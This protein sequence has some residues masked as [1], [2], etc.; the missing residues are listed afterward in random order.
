MVTTALTAAVTSVAT[1]VATAVATPFSNRLQSLIEQAPVTPLITVPA[2]VGALVS[3]CCY[4]LW[5]GKVRT[6]G[7]WAAAVAG[8]VLWPFRRI[9]WPQGLRSW[10]GRMLV[11]LAVGYI[12]ACLGAFTGLVGLVVVRVVAPSGACEPPRELRVITALENVTAL[13]ERAEAYTKE[14]RTDGCAPVRIAV[15][16]APTIEE[17]RYG[18]RNEWLRDDALQNDEPYRRMLGLTPDAWIPTGSAEF[19]LVVQDV[20]EKSGEKTK[21]G[22]VPEKT[23][24]LH[25]LLRKRNEQVGTDRMS[26]AV[27][28]AAKNDLLTSELES[29]GYPLAEIVRRA[30]SKDM[31]LVYPQPAFSTSGA[32]VATT[33]SRAGPQSGDTALHATFD[34]SAN[35]LLCHLRGADQKRTGEDWA[36]LVA[37]VPSHSADEYNRGSDMGIEACAHN[38]LAGRAALTAVSSVDLPTLDY[39]FV[40]INWSE[41]PARREALDA[42]ATWLAHNK[43]FEPAGEGPQPSSPARISA[44]AARP[45]HRVDLQMMIDGSGS[46][47]RSPTASASD[48]H[49]ALA[50]VRQILTDT[51]QVSAGKFF[52]DDSGTAKA[53]MAREGDAGGGE[54]PRGY[55]EILQWI[56]ADKQSGFDEPISTVIS[57]LRSPANSLAVITDGGPFNDEPDPGNA[58]RSIR[59]ALER[60]ADV[61]NLY[62]LTFGGKCPDGLEAPRAVRPSA[63]ASPSDG[64][65]GSLEP[66]AKHVVCDDTAGTDVAGALGR[67]IFQFRVWS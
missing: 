67:M 59:R 7:R 6:S 61:S 19:D 62:I 65:P 50:E 45:G 48:L 4:P 10:A 1:L 29:A 35:A 18:F 20:S 36:K 58:G 12:A 43:L 16:V 66:A 51:D 63:S 28:G 57:G 54:G 37:L 30:R 17:M 15:G 64:P 41:D 23:G 3:I 11:P 44:D 26:I 22:A 31:S 40:E 49:D 56:A 24:S 60:A 34:N 13:R 32:I 46:M 5:R 39:P 27:F 2:S 25:S 42:F 53:P 33:L 55:G 38:P 9:Q 14:Q 21:N 52:A 8:V 47:A